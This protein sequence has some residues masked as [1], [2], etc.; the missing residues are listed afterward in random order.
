MGATSGEKSRQLLTAPQRS[1]MMASHQRRS[2][3]NADLPL[4]RTMPESRAKPLDTPLPWRRD[5]A[6]LVALLVATVVL[7]GGA[8]AGQWEQLRR[9]RM[10]IG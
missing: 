6:A 4:V 2:G 7:R 5:V 9:I 10:P 1:A 3:S 8:M